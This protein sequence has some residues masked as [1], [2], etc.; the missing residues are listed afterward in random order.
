[1]KKTSFRSMQ[2]DDL[3]L[4]LDIYNHY[5]AT[6]TVTFDPSPISIETLRSRITV[7]NDL[8][9]A[10]VIHHL[11][12]IA[13]FCFLSRFEKLEAYDRTVEL[14]VYLKPEHVRQGLGTKSVRH[15]EEVAIAR[16]CPS[17]S[18]DEICKTFRGIRNCKGSYGNGGFDLRRE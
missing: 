7:N 14:G 9:K 10:Y 8:Y 11:G 17:G 18:G 12:E 5:I 6:T 4:V 15:L 16:G 3:P 2:E 13:G 1:M